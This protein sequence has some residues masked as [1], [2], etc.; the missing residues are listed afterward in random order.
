M[1]YNKLILFFCIIE[2]KAYRSV[3]DALRAQGT[4]T[5]NKHEVLKS[6]AATL[7]IGEERYRSEMRRA[8]NDDLLNTIA[9]R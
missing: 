6:L 9:Q 1:W 8:A 7:K 2:L 4:L 5:A 3:V